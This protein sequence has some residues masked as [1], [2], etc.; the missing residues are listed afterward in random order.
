MNELHP[1][2]ADIV[3]AALTTA[4]PVANEHEVKLSSTIEER[5]S[6]VAAD[7]PRM[8]QVIGNILS[9]AIK[10]T[11]A[12]KQ[13]ALELTR[14]DHKLKVSVTDQGEGIEEAFLPHVFERL[15][16]ADGPSNRAGLGLGLAIARHI[17]ELHHGEITAESQGPGQ[18]SRFTVTLP[19]AG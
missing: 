3:E 10:F 14:V 17:V 12:G 18:G 11:P 8:Q 4:R 16:Q 2:L 6:I 1:I 13:V 19:M 7:P 15:R 5:E 9:N